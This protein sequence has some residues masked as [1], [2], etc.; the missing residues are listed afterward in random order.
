MED[1]LLAAI[2]VRPV[3]E[4]HVE[5]R[6]RLQVRRVL[7]EQRRATTFHESLGPLT[8]VYQ[9]TE[10]S[11]GGARV[12]LVAQMPG[13][14]SMGGDL[15]EAARRDPA[16]REAVMADLRLIQASPDQPPAVEQRIAIDRLFVVPLRR[17]LD[18]AP[19]VRRVATG[20]AGKPAVSPLG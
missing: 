4:D 14:L 2:L 17:A 13:E 16:L 3:E 11:Q 12:V 1:H 7:P 19:K 9:A 8:T 15:A 18:R 6:V 5:V 20:K 10:V